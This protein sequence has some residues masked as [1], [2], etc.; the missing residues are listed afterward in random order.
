[1]GKHLPSVLFQNFRYSTWGMRQCV[2]VQNE[3]TGCEQDGPLLANLWMQ[4]ILQ[5][6]SAVCHCYSGHWRHSVAITPFLS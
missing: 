2:I 3:D 4:N 6:L 1:V 5:K